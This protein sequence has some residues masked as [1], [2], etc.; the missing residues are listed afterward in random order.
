MSVKHRVI[1]RKDHQV[2]NSEIYGRRISSAKRIMIKKP[3]H[4]TGPETCGC[5]WN[6]PRVYMLGAPGGRRRQGSDSL[7]ARSR[8]WVTPFARRLPDRGFRV[9]GY[10]NGD[11]QARTRLLRKRIEERQETS[12]DVNSTQAWIAATRDDVPRHD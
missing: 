12:R 3:A 6:K 4:G 9:G 5:S 2:V 1:K 8:G 10:G 7:V 11:R